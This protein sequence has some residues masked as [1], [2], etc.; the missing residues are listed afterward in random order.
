[1]DYFA[2]H[3]AQDFTKKLSPQECH[4]IISF[5]ILY[6]VNPIGWIK[7]WGKSSCMMYTKEGIKLSTV[8][9]MGIAD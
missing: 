9:N 7:T 2:A 3:F 6:M 5:G 4:T 1:M 8:H